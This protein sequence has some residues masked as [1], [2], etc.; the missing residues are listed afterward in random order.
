MNSKSNKRNVM[1]TLL[2]SMFLVLGSTLTSC[3]SPKDS[4]KKIEVNLFIAAS[5]S[6]AVDEIKADFE[7][8]NPNINV[9]INADSSGKLKAQIKE[10][11]ECDIFL[12]ASPKEIKELKEGSFLIDDSTV[13]LLENQLAIVAAKDYDG[14]VKDLKSIKLAKSIALPYGSVPAGFYARKALIA[15]GLL[16][17]TNLDNESIK[18]IT[19]QQVSVALD[20]LTISEQENVSKALSSV[21]EKSTEIGFTYVSDSFRNDNIKIIHK[22]DTDKT[23]KIIYPIAKVK[24]KN[25]EKDK[26]EAVEKLYK[27]LM[28]E[29][30]KKIYEKYGFNA[31]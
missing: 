9:V 7:K 6:D 18:A 14:N 28:N 23:G 31:N 2:V 29:K 11:F 22:I 16:A 27:F 8:E 20:N 10:G 4:G 19:G 21:S 5:L 13:D 12:S 26:K 17:P 25:D 30:S 1:I 15:E 3:S 24:S